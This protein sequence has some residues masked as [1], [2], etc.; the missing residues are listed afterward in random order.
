MYQDDID[1]YCDSCDAHLNRQDGFTTTTGS[2]ECTRC[3]SINNVT[4]D[5]ILSE[6]EAEEIYREECPK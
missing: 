3:G 2:W 4:E 5:Y 1:W 6:E